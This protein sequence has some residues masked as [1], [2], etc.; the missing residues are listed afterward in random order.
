[1]GV[2]A[3]PL[4][5]PVHDV[6]VHWQEPCEQTCPSEHMGFPPQ[7]HAPLGEQLS[8]SIEEHVLH[9]VPSLPQLGA[10]GVGLQAPAVVQQPVAQEAELQTQ[11]ES[12]H[13]SPCAHAPDVPHVH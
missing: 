5:H 4:Q 10:D 3:L 7:R 12:T 2:H 1:M 6:A 13:C 11:C 8:A 9:E